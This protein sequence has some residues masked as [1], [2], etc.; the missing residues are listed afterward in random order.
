MYIQYSWT[1][2][3]LCELMCVCVCL[4]ARALLCSTD[5]KNYS[6]AINYLKLK[7]CIIIFI[8]TKFQSILLLIDKNIIQ[9]K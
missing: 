7:L 4:R 5:V 2:F 1:V 6:N 9:R 3:S 8:I